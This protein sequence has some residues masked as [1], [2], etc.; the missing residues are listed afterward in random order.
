[1]KLLKF[2]L[3]CVLA[4]LA[5]PCLSEGLLLPETAAVLESEAFADTVAS[6]AYIPAACASIASDAFSDSVVAIYGSRGTAAERFALDSGRQFV[7]VGIYDVALDAPFLALPGAEIC[8]SA[9]WESALDVRASWQLF[10]ASGLVSSSDSG[11]L[12]AGERGSFDLALTLTNGFCTRRVLFPAAVEAMLPP[13]F[14]AASFELAVDQSAAILSEEEDRPCRLAADGAQGVRIEG[15]LV[16]ALRPGEWTVD[17]TVEQQ[18]LSYTVPCPVSVYEPVREISCLLPDYAYPGERLRLE[19]RLSPEDAKYTDL[20]YASSD[21]GVAVVDESGLVTLR[22]P[23]RATLT[24][25][26]KDKT[27]AFELVCVPRP[28]SVSL[29]PAETSLAQNGVMRL[30]A[31]LLPEGALAPLRWSVS[32]DSVLS[33][34]ENGLV[35]GLDVGSAQVSCSWEDLSASCALFVKTAPQELTLSS[36]FTYLPIGLSRPLELIRQPEQTEMDRIVWQSSDPAV[37][38]VD[39]SGLVSAVGEGTCVITALAQSRAS[40]AFTVHV[41]PCGTDTGLSFSGERHYVEVGESLDL[42]LGVRL[43]ES[44]TL[45]WSVSDESVLSVDQSGAV[46]G[47]SPGTA[48][49]TVRLEGDESVFAVA[50][51]NVLSASRCLTMPLKRTPLSGIDANLQRITAVKRSALT[52]LDSLFARGLIDETERAARRALM[53]RAF[54]AYAFPWTPGQSVPYWNAV[55]SNGGIKDFEPGVIYYGLPYISGDYDLNR[56]YNVPKAL[57]EGRYVQSPRGDHYVMDTDKLLIGKYVGCDCSTFVGMSYFGN[58]A[59]GSKARTTLLY[60]SPDFI[61]KTYD[62]VLF[63]GDILVANY[64]HVVMFLY[65]ANGDRTQIVTLEQGGLKIDA[66]TVLADV[67]PIRYFQDNHFIPRRLRNWSALAN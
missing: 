31:R 64:R 49:V 55:N 20:R 18:G 10:S 45:V 25:S 12:M 5:L 23:G 27:A 44:G 47:V 33:V 6:W 21:S 3:A 38:A 48:Q 62:D 9:S 43:R 66:A 37:A 16:T 34:D 11:L 32:D 39:Q 15:G 22:A 50:Y 29:L 41:P 35:T 56:S 1:M 26:T 36:D 51:V 60:S 13:R 58:T 59:K 4:L 42:P 19:A 63:P 7:D 53:D 61:T 17:V 14:A 46:T 30:E 24:L 52:E 67:Y 28:V 2:L 57:S 65:Y 8:V 40:A 54:E